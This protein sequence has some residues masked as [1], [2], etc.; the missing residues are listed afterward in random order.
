MVASDHGQ[1]Y[2]TTD[3]IPLII[4][5][6]NGQFARRIQNNVQI[7]DIAP[8]LLDYIGIEKPTWMQGDSL[9]GN[10]PA[11]RLIWGFAAYNIPKEE[12]DD[13]PMLNESQLVPPFYQFGFASAI[14]CQQWY[15]LDLLTRQLT[16]GVVKD[17]TA[18]CPQ[19]ELISADQFVEALAEHFQEQ[20]YDATSLTLAP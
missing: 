13:I 4:Y 12:K 1:F 5:F 2:T 7:I 6:P 19:S 20:G 14:N 9:L 17:H 18:P 15:A 11:K 3:R 16:S 10:L 8:T